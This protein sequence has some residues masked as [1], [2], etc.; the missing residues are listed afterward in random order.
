MKSKVWLITGASKGFGKVWAEAALK[1]G[2][3]VVATARNISDLSELIDTY[4]SSVL[5]VKLDV[6]SR[7]ACFA[8]VEQGVKQF[9]RIDVLI[10]NAGYG[11]F[12]FIEEITETEAREQFETNVFGSLWMMQ[13][14]LPIMRKQNSGHILQVSSI[15]GVIAFPSIGIYHGTKWAVEGIC[16]SLS[17]EVAGFGIKVTLIEPAGYATDWGGSS[18]KHSAS[19]EAYKPVQEAL[20]ASMSGVEYGNPAHTADAILKVVSSE[21]PPLRLFLGTM[22]NA[23]I[24]SAYQKRLDEWEAWKEVSEAAQ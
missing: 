14:V 3:K 18:S 17:Q 16:E 5:P 23:I 11:H 10:N 9:G 22:P 1:Q 2:D 12:G 6:N 4:G 24:G 19:I 21:N 13:A 20:N 8:A 7:E 15:G